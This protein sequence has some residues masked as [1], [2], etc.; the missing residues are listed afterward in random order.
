MNE[1][2]LRPSKAFSADH[3]GKR[4]GFISIT[5]DHCVRIQIVTATVGPYGANYPAMRDENG[6]L[7]MSRE[8]SSGF[9]SAAS[10][11]YTHWD[12]G[13]GSTSHL[14]SFVYEGMESEQG[15]IM[16]S[17]IIMDYWTRGLPR[18]GIMQWFDD[19]TSLV[20]A[21]RMQLPQDL[22]ERIYYAWNIQIGTAA[23]S[24]SAALGDVLLVDY[25]M[26]GRTLQV[27]D[28]LLSTLGFIRECAVLQQSVRQMQDMNIFA[29]REDR[30][31]KTNAE[32][33]RHAILKLQNAANWRAWDDSM[34]SP[35]AEIAYNCPSANH[36]AP[37]P[38][39]RIMQLEKLIAALDPLTQAEFAVYAQ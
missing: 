28:G 6:R 14:T 13:F 39:E 35:L 29:E 24:F 30:N 16:E 22:Y 5:R 25:G 7:L 37:T 32:T 4:V 3:A 12:D 20:N 10:L 36:I 38:H 11:N 31:D 23:K 8:G 17:G 19:M 1:R 15:G 33:A 2:T 27:K 18:Y 9:E 26:S 21:L 34:A